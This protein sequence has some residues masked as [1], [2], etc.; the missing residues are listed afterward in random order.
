MGFALWMDGDRAWAQGTSEY[1]AMGVAVVAISDLFRQ[2]DF[3]PRRRTP[4]GKEYVGLFASVGQLNA[5]LRRRR[6]GVKSK[7]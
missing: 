5:E 3:R 2:S 4:L 1:R 7:A 6:R